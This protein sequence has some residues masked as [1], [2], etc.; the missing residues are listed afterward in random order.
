M[1]E[2]TIKN[3]HFHQKNKRLFQT[4]TNGYDNHYKVVVSTIS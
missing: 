4:K 1:V 3:G 2:L